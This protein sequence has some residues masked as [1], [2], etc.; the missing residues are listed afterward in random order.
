MGKHD[1]ASYDEQSILD[2]PRPHLYA[3]PKDRRRQYARRHRALADYMSGA[4]LAGAAK[5]HGISRSTLKRLVEL[6]SRLD[7]AG[8]PYGFRVCIPYFRADTPPL[9]GDKPQT[10]LSA[11]PHSFTKLLA[12]NATIRDLVLT[13]DGP[14]PVGR[15]HSAAFDRLHRQF[16][17]QLGK[18]THLYPL[19]TRDKGRRALLE[20]LRRHRRDNN[21][22]ASGISTQSPKQPAVERLD[23]LF[24]LTPFMR[25]EY[26]AHDVDVKW[27]IEVLGPGNAWVTRS[28]SK[29]LFLVAI[30]AVSR[31]VI[32]WLLIFGRGYR[33]FDLME[34]F[35]KGMCPWKPRTITVPGLCYVAGSGMPSGMMSNDLAP[36][37]LLTAGDNFSGHQAPLIVHN[38][39]HTHLGV[40]NWAQ[41][42]IPEKRPIV[43][44]FFRHLEHGALRD[45][46]GGFVPATTRGEKPTAANCLDPMRHPLNVQALQ[47]LMDVI[48]TAYNADAHRGLRDKSPLQV[49]SEYIEHGGWIWQSRLSKDHAQ[50]M[51]L[52]HIYVTIRG[53]RKQSRQ[54]FV[55]WKGARY[56]SD[57]LIN[58]FDLVGKKF[59]ASI[60]S[61]DLRWMTLYDESGDV[62]VRLPALHPWHAQKHDVRLREQIT[63]WD[64]AKVLSI[65][66]V[67]DAIAAYHH[68][69]RETAHANQTSADQYARHQQAQQAL[70]KKRKSRSTAAPLTTPREGWIGA[71]NMEDLP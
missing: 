2:W 29:V 64:H 45:I 59:K 21:L 18:N 3:I 42:H 70:P 27:H 37:S 46:A 14:L 33:Q 41:A 8:S 63:K 71:E 26:D 69:V 32:S 48:V 9:D 10:P 30:D 51:T 65:R 52:M 5:H 57:A 55:Q 16:T 23:Q 15:K 60:P 7:P 35:A 53:S 56:R 66:G 11:A 31:L 67:D 61:Q 22:V 39:L 17:K 40:W 62:L 20:Y 47:E 36:R 50:K 13:F 25:T 68:Y 49:L 38:M 4:T 43:E 12:S 6:A 19:D 54:P 24:P 34:M 28:I 1:R 44:S 58:R